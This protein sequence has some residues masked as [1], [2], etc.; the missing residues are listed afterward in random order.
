VSKFL[1]VTTP[2]RVALGSTSP[3]ALDST[4]ASTWQAVT[5]LVRNAYIKAILPGFDRQGGE[6]KRA[7][8]G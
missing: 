5:N 3:A 2:A 8:Q 1:V 4:H 7:G 6:P